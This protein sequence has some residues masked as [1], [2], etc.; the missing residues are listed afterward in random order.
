MDSVVVSTV[1]YV[2]PREVYEFLVD[3]EGYAG[4][5]EYLESVRRDGDGAEGTVYE[6][7]VG[8]W[9]L[10]HTVRSEV[11][12]VDPPSRI[13]WR[14]LGSIGAR[15]SWRI[16]SL[17]GD[18]TEASN[19]EA[20]PA[21]GPATLVSLVVRYDPDTVDGSGIDLPAFVSLDFLVDRV[22]PL[23]REEAERVVERIVADLE[24]QRRDVSLHVG[25]EPV[26]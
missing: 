12:A 18:E 10:E 19:L 24:G 6:I 5:S 23:V 20:A 13:D 17:D 16:R 22:E 14:L 21:D 2:E 11:T 9:R 26:E 15:G 4:Y 7:T 1:V 3:F 8:W 25:T